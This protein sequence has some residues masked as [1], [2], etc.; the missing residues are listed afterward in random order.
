MIQGAIPL[1]TIS[2]KFLSFWT[3]SLEVWLIQ[4]EAQFEKKKIRSTRS[5]FTHC[6]AA[7]PQDVACRLLYLVQGPLVKPYKALRRCVIQMYSLRDFQIDQA[8]QRLPFLFDQCPSELMDK[9]LVQEACFFSLEACSFTASQL[10]FELICSLYPSMT[11]EEG[12]S[13]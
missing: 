3:N 2:V 8:L 12:L 4:A 5:K 13:G 7:L 10:I 1:T 11:L 9:M 6:V